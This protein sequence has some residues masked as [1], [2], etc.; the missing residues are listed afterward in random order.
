[1][2]QIPLTRRIAAAAAYAA[3]VLVASLVGV[4]SAAA[5]AG[6]TVTITNAGKVPISIN[7]KSLKD[8][9]EDLNGGESK[10][11]PASYLAGV[12]TT[13]NNITWEARLRD[14]GSTSQTRP[15]KVCAE[16]V[17]IWQGQA[18]RINVTKCDQAAA[19]AAP[20]PSAAPKP[21]S[22]ALQQAYG[23]QWGDYCLSKD[24]SACCTAS[25]RFTGTPDCK[26][27]DTCKV[28]V[29]ICQVMVSCNATLNSCKRSATGA[30]AE[31]CTSDY[32]IC[33]DKALTLAN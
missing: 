6:P 21:I 2:F 29:H 16:G 31:K 1:M 5:Q 13:N 24:S 11:V 10:T 7:I 17:I 22:M 25:E 28:S 3:A 30:A 9:R 14:L 12:S 4:G 26:T 23:K 27:A 15:N 8:Y 33:H 19:A 20:A 18:G 32:K